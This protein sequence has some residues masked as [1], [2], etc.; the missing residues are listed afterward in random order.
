MVEISSR[1]RRDIVDALRRG[2][3]PQQGLDVMAV[4]LARFEAA[5]DAELD[6]APGGGAGFN[7]VRGE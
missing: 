6:L 3:V 5:L 1:R 7:A 2:T 4:G